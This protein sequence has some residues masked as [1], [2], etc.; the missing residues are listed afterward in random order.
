MPWLKVSDTAANNPRVLAPLTDS[1]GD[2]LDPYDRVNLLFGLVVRCATLSAGYLTDYIVSDATV[3][4]LGGARWLDHATAAERAGYWSRVDG[5]WLIAEDPTNL[6]HIRR[7][8]EIEWERQRKK[9]TSTPSLV[10]PVRL[11]DGDGCR[12]CGRIVTWGDQRGGRGG[13]YDHRTPGVSAASPE[14]LRVAC[15]SCNAR[16]G[17]DPDADQHIPPLPVPAAPFYGPRTVA[18]LAEHGHQ[19]PEGS[20]RPGTRPDPARRD[21]AS[22]GTPRPNNTDGDPATR[23]RTRRATRHPAGPRATATPRDPAPGGTPRPAPATGRRPPSATRQPAGPRA[24]DTPPPAEPIDP[25][26]IDDRLRSTDSANRRSTE[27]G[28]PG[29]DGQASPGPDRDATSAARG[30]AA[31]RPRRRRRARR[32]RP[33]GTTT[34]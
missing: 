18:L 29:R 14:D 20:A 4:Q 15:R 1:G 25:A 3:A 33:P 16:R 21:P 8:E 34:S 6:L 23:R 32:S 17:N 19:V 2:G 28:S 11:R 31:G 9:D 13:T 7:A 10:V 22:G 30:R 5:G 12:Y 27:P 24:V 26:P